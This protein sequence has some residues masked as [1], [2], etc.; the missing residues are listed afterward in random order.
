M[1]FVAGVAFGGGGFSCIASFQIFPDNEELNNTLGGF[2]I[3][4]PFL[5]AFR[6][7]TVAPENALG[8]ELLAFFQLHT[9]SLRPRPPA[10][11]HVAWIIAMIQTRQ[12]TAGG[13]HQERAALRGHEPK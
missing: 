12:R 11:F 9:V 1:L 3:S 7:G 13:I 2:A 6:L 4:S 5:G 8:V 10:R